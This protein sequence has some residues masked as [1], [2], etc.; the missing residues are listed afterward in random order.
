MAPE[1]SPPVAE[2]VDAA[3]MGRE[4]RALFAET[5]APSP[6]PAALRQRPAPIEIGFVLHRAGYGGA[7]RV[8]CALAK[9]AARAGMRP[10]LY[11]CGESAQA[12]PGFAEAFAGVE[13][14]DLS[15]PEAA[16][17][18]LSRHHAVLASQVDAAP[19]LFAALRAR[20]VVTAAHVHLVDRTALDR[21]SGFINATLDHIDDA[22][23]V[24]AASRDV[25]GRMTALGAPEA[26]IAVLENAPGFP[27]APGRAEAS[28]AARLERLRRGEALR[29]L[30]LGRLDRQKG[31]GV[32]DALARITARPDAAPRVAWRIVGDSV[33]G[34]DAPAAL[35]RRAAA[36]VVEAE[37]LQAL[38]DWADVVVLP[39]LYEGAPLALLEAM[40]A[41]AI[42]VATAVGAVSELVADGRT[43][44]LLRPA[45]A[46]ADGLAALTKLD[47]DREAAA[48]IA[49]DA[50]RSMAGRDWA[51]T[52]AGP[53]ARLRSI[54]EGAA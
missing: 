14:L 24:F 50:H 54:I 16:L 19:A 44:V 36:P 40:R 26:R 2:A 9:Q 6:R 34:G 42:P 38:Y 27:L 13:T 39:S 17:A 30:Y 20:G 3:T 52:A 32:L 11:L 51:A 4:W 45:R 28:L 5:R 31:L 10:H 22:D 43:G 47:A 25:A 7:E 48:A 49:I 18:A 33:L 35:A 8:A 15:R 37:A 1:L 21:D 12:A 46:L 23:I 29:A 41:G 53:L